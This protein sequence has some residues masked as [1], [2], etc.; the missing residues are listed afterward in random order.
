M[1][2]ELP[3]QLPRKRKVD[4]KIKLELGVKPP[5][6]A[7]YRMAPAEFEELKK[8]LKNLLDVGFIHPSKKFINGYSTKAAPLTDLLKKNHSWEEEQEL[9]LS[10]YSKVFEVYTNA[11]N[12]AI[13]G[14][15]MQE[16]HSIAFESHKLNDTER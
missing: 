12:Y 11:S 8:Q 7:P 16:G 1:P 9:A 3:K 13:G 2:L 10:N 6:S 5:A 15:L 14:V 4:H